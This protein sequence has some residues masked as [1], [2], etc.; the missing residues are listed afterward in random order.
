MISFRHLDLAAIKPGCAYHQRY[1]IIDLYKIIDAQLSN[2]EQ[3]EAEFKIVAQ[4]VVKTMPSRK[5]ISA[6][7]ERLYGAILSQ[8]HQPLKWKLECVRELLVEGR[9]IA[10]DQY[11]FA[12]ELQYRERLRDMNTMLL[13]CI[14][15]LYLTNPLVLSQMPVQTLKN[16]ANVMHLDFLDHGFKI[17]RAIGK[18]YSDHQCDYLKGWRYPYLIQLFCRCDDDDDHPP[19]FDHL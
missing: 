15:S 11:C 10:F 9:Y 18:T 14:H 3:M 2:F 12:L 5:S 13:K 6:R 1:N 19:I 7:L 8:H 16:F 17:V 4:D